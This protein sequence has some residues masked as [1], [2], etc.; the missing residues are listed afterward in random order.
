MSTHWSMEPLP[1]SEWDNFCAD[2][3]YLLGTKE[4]QAIIPGTVLVFS[5]LPSAPNHP[6][7]FFLLPEYRSNIPVLF[8]SSVLTL[9]QV[10]VSHLDH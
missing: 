4:A 6:V 10:I 8:I 5:H 3:T 2:P 1:R 7:L 9:V